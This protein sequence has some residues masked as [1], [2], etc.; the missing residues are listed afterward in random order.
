MKPSIEAYLS[1]CQT[2][3]NAA[4][5]SILGAV[6][7]QHAALTRLHKAMS[8]SVLQGGKRTRPALLYAS[9]EA[10]TGQPASAAADTPAAAMELIHA[11][12][13]VHDDLPAMDNDDL[14]RGQPTC[15]RAFDEPT[16]ILAGDA[17]QTLA[18]E[19][20]A[21]D[22][23]LSESLRLQLIRLLAV[24]SGHAGMCG[25][26]AIDLQLTGCQPGLAT[27]EH[28]HR[29]KTGALIE[30]AVRMGATMAHATSAQTEALVGFARPIGL[31][32]QVH[33]DILDVIA[34]TATLGK[35]QGADQARSKPTF[36]SLLGLDGAQQ[37]A[38]ALEQQALASLDALGESAD[39]LRALAHWIIHRHH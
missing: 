26:Q 13:L 5:Q 9:M 18:F 20:L 10:C 30:T 35:T 28:M 12:S 24:G 38:R 16:A 3:V 22:E 15:H 1:G 34:D 23:H 33:D 29:L 32:F 25:G 8:Y 14:R 2:R 31:A 39:S 17:L 6:P 37:H 4:M 21:H 27:L 7:E 11:Y 19:A 36:P